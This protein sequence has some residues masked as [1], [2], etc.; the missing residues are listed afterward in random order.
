MIESKKYG[1]LT[2]CYNE[3]FI[4]LSQLKVTHKQLVLLQG[5]FAAYFSGNHG[6]VDTLLKEMKAKLSKQ[7]QNHEPP[8]W[9]EELPGSR[10]HE[11]QNQD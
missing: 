7:S 6:A 2:L 11:Q 1:E 5:A 9:L 8:S 4:S 3:W 10:E